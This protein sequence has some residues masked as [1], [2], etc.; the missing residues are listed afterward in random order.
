MRIRRTID[1]AFTDFDLVVLPTAR[2]APMPLKYV[3]EQAE[4]PKPRNPNE[5]SE[6][7][8]INCWPFNVLGIPAISI[9]CGF[10]REGLPI[11]LMIAGPR[12]SE[13]RIMALAKAYELRTK[14]DEQ[15][16]RLTPNTLVPPIADH[17]DF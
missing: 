6:V 5:A 1:D 3:V 14:W 9:P 17:V 16:P 8:A 10:S 15:R 11:G 2:V 7:S 13:G 12:F 4:N